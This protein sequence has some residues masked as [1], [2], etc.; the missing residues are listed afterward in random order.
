LRNC[1]RSFGQGAGTAPSV[2]GL[3]FLIDNALPP[4][5]ADLLPWWQDMTRCLEPELVA[6]CAAV[7][8]K[9]R[10]RVR[11]LPFAG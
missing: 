7:F 10:L 5:L 3:R 1:G 8:R 9:S 2:L 6:G 4:L 11:N